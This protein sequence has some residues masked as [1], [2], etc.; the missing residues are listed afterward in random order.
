M[1]IDANAASEPAPFKRNLS[2]SLHPCLPINL[3]LARISQRERIPTLPATPPNSCPL[4]LR[5]REPLSAASFLCYQR[6]A[7]NTVAHVS[8]LV[9]PGPTV[10]TPAP[11]PPDQP[12]IEDWDP[13]QLHFW[14]HLSGLQRCSALWAVTRMG[15]AFTQ[16]PLAAVKTLPRLQHSHAF[17]IPMPSSLARFEMGIDTPNVLVQIPT[18]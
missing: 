9:G 4:P 2:R 6:T 10:A 5:R 3:L 14:G 16:E 8:T 12:L 1:G 18:H 13:A 11:Y 15:L 7:L 17:S